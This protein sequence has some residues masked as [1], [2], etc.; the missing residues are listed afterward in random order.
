MGIRSSRPTP[1]YDEDSLL[2]GL[3][4]GLTYDELERD[5]GLLPGDADR[6]VADL[7]LEYDIE[8]VKLSRGRVWALSDPLAI[9]DGD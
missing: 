9:L 5:H 4:T 3:A 2:R 7:R 1:S 6:V 8:R